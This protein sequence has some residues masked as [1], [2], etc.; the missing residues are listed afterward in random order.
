M[1]KREANHRIALP[2]MPLVKTLTA[3]A[4]VLAVGVKQRSGLRRRVIY[5]ARAFAGEAGLHELGDTADAHFLHR[6]RAMRLD[7]FHADA[8]VFGYLP[9]LTAVYYELEN[10]ALA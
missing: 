1:P 3:Y 7:S 8:E 6:V 2:G 4:A 10:L 5:L 9:V